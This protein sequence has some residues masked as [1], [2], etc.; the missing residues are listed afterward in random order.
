MTDFNMNDGEDS[1]EFEIDED[2]G[3]LRIS[4]SGGQ[5]GWW[6]TEEQEI[7]LA[8][9]LY[10]KHLKDIKPISSRVNLEELRLF[11]EWQAKQ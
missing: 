1:G 10:N 7:K 9:H 6:M 3:R 11:R 2:K 5:V 4:A 8:N